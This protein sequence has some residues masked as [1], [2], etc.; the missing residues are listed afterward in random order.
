MLILIII[1]ILVFGLGGGYYGANTANFATSAGTAGTA[2]NAL[3]LGSVR[4]GNYARLDIG[5]IFSASQTINS[6]LGVNGT[7]NALALNVGVGGIVV[8]P[9]NLF[10]FGSL[11]SLGLLQIGSSGTPIVKHLSQTPNIT[12]PAI[13]PN[14]CATLSPVTFPGASDGDT[15][16]LGVKNALTSGG[17]LTYFAWVSATDTITIKVCNPHGTTNSALSGAIRVDIWKH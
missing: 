11:N 5:N 10:V 8:N 7:I 14:Q 3:S 12:V 9:G 2:T 6:N 13:V 17:N 16:A 4:A 15:I 1:L